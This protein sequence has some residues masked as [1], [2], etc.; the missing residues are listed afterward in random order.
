M[1][2]R[3][4]ILMIEKGNIKIWCLVL[5]V[6][7]STGCQLAGVAQPKQMFL[8]STRVLLQRD[9]LDF[10]LLIFLMREGVM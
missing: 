2:V 3:E 8:F 4:E 5:G 9:K 1:I 6:F 10:S 7:F